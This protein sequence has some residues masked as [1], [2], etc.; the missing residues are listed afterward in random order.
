MRPSPLPPTPWGLTPSQATI[1]DAIVRHGIAKAAARELGLDKN[2]LTATM[3][4]VRK[5]MGVQTNL[6]AYI[7]WAKR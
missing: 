5:K 1:I 6:H 2:T 3:A 7:E 4:A